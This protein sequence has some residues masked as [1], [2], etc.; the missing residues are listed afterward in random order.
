M[1][2]HF[3]MILA[4]IVVLSSATVGYVFGLSKQHSA[5]VQ[6]AVEQPK[7]TP[8]AEGSTVDG[9]N[10]ILNVAVAWKQTAAEYKA[11]YHQ[12]FNMARIQVDRAL[13]NR[14]EGDK[15]LAVITD[16]DDTILSPVNYWG[17]LINNNK[18]FFDDAIWDKWIPTYNMAATAGALDFF[19]YCKKKGV[20]VFY[21]SSRDQGSKTYHYAKTQLK[22]LKFPYVDKKHLTILR[23]TSNKEP[24][25]NEIAQNYKV[26]SYL[27]DNLND[28]RRIYYVAD[29]D[30]RAKLME[31]DKDLFGTKFILMPNPT[32]GH[33]VRAIFGESEP[34]ATDNNRVIWKEAATR[35]AW[36]QK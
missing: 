28:F 30:K 34:A 17:Y 6:A 23:D 26:I 4:I 31:Q 12:S 8:S 1:K 3:S 27:G 14:K 20:E 25:Q 18:D 36:K 13:A 21:V 15:P 19:N 32:D 33:W 22:K 2:R 11:L 5:H 29:I 10:N 7:I 24:R 35:S 9:L 16:I